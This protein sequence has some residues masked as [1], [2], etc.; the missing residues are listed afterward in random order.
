MALTAAEQPDTQGAPAGSW[1]D[2]I[3]DTLGGLTEVYG[4]IAQIDGEQNRMQTQADLAEV[5]LRQAELNLIDAHTMSSGG[6][7]AVAGIPWNLV[8]GGAGVALVGAVLIFRG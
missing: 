1:W 6:G 2:A 3:S 7:E 5:Q 8:I 4:R